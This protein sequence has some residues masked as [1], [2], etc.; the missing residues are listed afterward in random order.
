[1]KTLIKGLMEKY[2]LDMLADEQLEAWKSPDI[3]GENYRMDAEHAEDSV[4]FFLDEVEE[5]GELEDLWRLVIH[6][7]DWKRLADR[8]VEAATVRW[9]DDMIFNKMVKR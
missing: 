3:C 1:M 4:R 9:E 8:A 6:F 2:W 5:D 7:A